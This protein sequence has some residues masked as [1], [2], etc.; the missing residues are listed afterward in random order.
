M[1]GFVRNSKGNFGQ[2]PTVVRVNA[3]TGAQTLISGGEVNSTLPLTQPE[4]AIIGKDGNYLI[5]NYNSALSGVVKVNAASG[6][7]SVLT[8]GTYFSNSLVFGIWQEKSNAS[9]ILVSEASLVNQNLSGLVEVD[10]DTGA[11]TMI[12]QGG[13]LR[14]PVAL[15]QDQ[16]GATFVSS[17]ETSKEPWVGSIFQVDLGTGAQS[18]ISTGGHLMRPQAILADSSVPEPGALALFGL[19]AGMLSV[20]RRAR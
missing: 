20:R 11:Q 16:F 15:A 4:G 1:G 3:V 17:A 6:A 13:G 5:D 8:S 9:K 2:S 19:G 14:F 10:E 18:L 12:S 7:Q